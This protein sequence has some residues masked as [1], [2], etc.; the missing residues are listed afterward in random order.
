MDKFVSKPKAK[1]IV[2]VDGTTYELTKPTVAMKQDLSLKLN[3]KDAKAPNTTDCLVSFVASLGLP[4]EVIE[5]MD[6]DNFIELVE[7]ISKKKT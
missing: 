1:M 2:E 7:F 6:E 3:S 5:S 4:K